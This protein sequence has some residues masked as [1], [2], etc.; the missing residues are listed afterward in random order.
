MIIAFAALTY[1]WLKTPQLVDT[2]TYVPIAI[3]CVGGS[4]WMS[5]KAQSTTTPKNIPTVDKVP[6]AAAIPAAEIK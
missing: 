3:A 4:M 1:G 2:A 5:N 6:P